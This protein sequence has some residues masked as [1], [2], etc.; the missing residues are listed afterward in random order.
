MRPRG[1][2]GA[3]VSNESCLITMSII[4]A[5]NLELQIIQIVKLR[6]KPTNEPLVLI[7]LC[8]SY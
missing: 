8:L 2:F 3:G 5:Q 4:R 7:Y 1:S 6:R